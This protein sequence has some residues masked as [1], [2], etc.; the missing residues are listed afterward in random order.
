MS[1][2][3]TYRQ[4]RPKPRQIHPIWRGIGCLMAIIIPAISVIIAWLIVDATWTRL[5]Y[6]LVAPISLPEF[7]YRYLPQVAN[8]VGSIL[9]R[10]KLLAY[11]LFTIFALLILTGILSVVYALIYRFIGPPRYSPVDAPPPKGKVKR[12][13]R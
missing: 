3:S 13:K 11:V 8:V 12:Y 9:Y 5:P 10:P 2:Y 7:M 1:K 4:V 6:W